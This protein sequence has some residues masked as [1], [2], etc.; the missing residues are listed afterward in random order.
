[1]LKYI[2]TSKIGTIF[3]SYNLNTSNILDFLIT[4]DNDNLKQLLKLYLLS[5]LEDYKH[6]EK[7]TDNIYFSQV[8]S[9]T[10]TNEII[11]KLPIKQFWQKVKER[12]NTKDLS[13]ERIWLAKNFDSYLYYVVGKE[14]REQIQAELK[15]R[16][17]QE[18][19]IF[20]RKK[21]KSELQDKIESASDLEKDIKEKYESN[22][23]SL[24]GLE[25]LSATITTLVEYLKSTASKKGQSFNPYQETPRVFRF[26]FTYLDERKTI[27]FLKE[28]LVFNYF[29]I[30]K[31]FS[32]SI[33]KED[34]LKEILFYIRK[35]MS[36]YD[37]TAKDQTIDSDI[38][39]RGLPAS[40]NPLGPEYRN[41]EITSDNEFFNKT[42]N[43]KD[44][45][46]DMED[47]F[48]RFNKI[49]QITD[50]LEYAQECYKLSQEFLQIHPYI[51]G[52]GRT[53]K[54]LFY[55]LLLKRNI[56]PFTITDNN[57]LTPCY[58]DTSINK[59]NYFEYRNSVMTRRSGL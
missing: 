34:N 33:L 2:E 56:L 42:T 5:T 48:E 46:N 32:S 11:L 13:E 19:N 31:I 17:K 7:L 4:E 12:E 37:I 9:E 22:F 23:G 53:S 16:I 14:S 40:T 59:E 49:N 20:K 28:D 35:L 15:Q 43:P 44:I 36:D 58:E 57:S 27:D 21:L 18:R 6:I 25:E 38:D 30:T 26:I 29:M 55:I 39:Y 47:L 50:D 3:N 52:N 54:F 24:N 10:P 45:A 51:N 8:F 1:M 41:V